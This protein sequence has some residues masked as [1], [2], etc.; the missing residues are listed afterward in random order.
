[1]NKND[2]PFQDLIE[3][4]NRN[5]RI[6]ANTALIDKV[7]D[8][9]EKKKKIIFEKVVDFENKS[10][11]IPASIE[12]FIT[13]LLEK[14]EERK[15]LR[16]EWGNLGDKRVE[17]DK[18]TNGSEKIIMERG[19]YNLNYEEKKEIEI[20]IKQYEEISIK[21]ENLLNKRIQIQEM[22]KTALNEIEKIIARI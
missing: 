9:V 10:I 21:Q 13:I 2:N 8:E 4:H 5:K 20:L 15:K 22:E 12:S 19:G 6:E 18:Y 17:M 7:S 16:I 3:L 1:M 11:Q 14:V